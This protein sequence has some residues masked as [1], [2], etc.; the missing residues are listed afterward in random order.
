MTIQSSLMVAFA[1]LGVCA[2]IASVLSLTHLTEEA[3]RSRSG[4]FFAFGPTLRDDSFDPRGK[5]FR[6]WAVILLLL[7]FAALAVWASL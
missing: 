2:L 1:S 6:R 5:R 4:P 7:A 3:K